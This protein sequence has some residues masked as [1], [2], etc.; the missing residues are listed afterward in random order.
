MRD[1][2]DCDLVHRLVELFDK[3]LHGVDLLLGLFGNPF[4]DRLNC[5]NVIIIVVIIE[6]LFV[7]A[8]KNIANDRV[9]NVSIDDKFDQIRS[10]V[11]VLV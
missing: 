3:Q 1:V 2:L 11:H 7:I 9:D 5:C 4:L 10:Q 8:E 6:Q